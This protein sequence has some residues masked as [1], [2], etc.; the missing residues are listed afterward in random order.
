VTA[1]PISNRQ[2]AASCTL[3]SPSVLLCKATSKRFSPV[4]NLR[5]LSIEG[6]VLRQHYFQPFVYHLCEVTLF[7]VVTLTHLISSSEWALRR[8]STLISWENFSHHF[9]AGSLSSFVKEF[10][11]PH[12]S[13]TACCSVPKMLKVISLS[14]ESCWYLVPLSFVPYHWSGVCF[15]L[16]I[17]MDHGFYK[18]F[19]ILVYVWSLVRRFVDRKCL[20]NRFLTF[21]TL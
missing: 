12:T 5:L 14:R 13:C 4:F 2:T 9:L 10:R 1:L 20:V 16:F 17:Q 8:F 11:Y 7:V 6:C 21:T 19:C 18:Q 15:W 3:A